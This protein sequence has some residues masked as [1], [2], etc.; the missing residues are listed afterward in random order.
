MSQRRSRRLP[1]LKKK[2]EKAIEKATKAEKK[3]KDIEVKI[4]EKKWKKKRLAIKKAKRE[5]K[6][7]IAEREAALL[8][9]KNNKKNKVKTIFCYL[10]LHQIITMFKNQVLPEP[11]A[12]QIES[13]DMQL[14]SAE[15]HFDT[16]FTRISEISKQFNTSGNDSI[17]TEVKDMSN[18]LPPVSSISPTV[19]NGHLI[20]SG[21]SAQQQHVKANLVVASTDKVTPL[22][23]SVSKNEFL[24][25]LS[26]SQIGQG[27]GRKS[28]PVKIAPKSRDS[29]A[30]KRVTEP[31]KNTVKLPSKI[32]IVRK[33]AFDKTSRTV[34]TLKS[35]LN[36]SPHIVQ[37]NVGKIVQQFQAPSSSTTLQQQPK[38][39]G[40]STPTIKCKAFSSTA[41]ALKTYVAE[42]LKMLQPAAKALILKK[43]EPAKTPP[44][45]AAQTKSPNP[46]CPV[47]PKNTEVVSR[48]E[49]MEPSSPAPQNELVIYSV[50]VSVFLC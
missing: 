36:A 25:L 23:T 38:L 21:P 19:S 39:V 8:L 41:P 13:I 9:R 27:S 26:L 45:V 1:I 34:I 24:Q 50:V 48:M 37:N 20:I 44:T 2:K 10:E 4:R 5:A 12:N 31:L 22:A 3:A 7:K 43:G 42:P 33:D 47:V 35:S 28:T 46:P 18:T 11:N 16:S 29:N 15:D 32:L 14:P 40:N 6:I 49:M 17:T 30:P